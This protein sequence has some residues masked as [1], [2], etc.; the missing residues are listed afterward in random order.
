MPPETRL[1][2]FA[3]RK[4]PRQKRSQ[5]VVGRILATAAALFEQEGYAYVSTNRIAEAANVSIGSIYQYFAN[6]ESIA[7]AIYEAACSQA[8]LTLKSQAIARMDL[9]LAAAIHAHMDLLF[10]LFERDRYALFQILN[11]VPELRDA[12]QPIS[13]DRI[14]HQAHRMFLEQHFHAA[15]PVAISRKC[16]FIEKTVI[17]AIGHYLDER[18]DFLT[19][20]EAVTEVAQFVQR[21]VTSLHE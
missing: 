19:R 13:F 12:A 1:P 4:R 18:P 16:Y 5:I 7:L 11:E 2:H 17:S 21:Y 9:P 3:A 15:D 6:R 20:D 10:D 14:I 8:A